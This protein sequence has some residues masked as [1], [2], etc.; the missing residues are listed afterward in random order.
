MKMLM[1]AASWLP[2]PLYLQGVLG[3]GEWFGWTSSVGSHLWSGNDFASPGRFAV[4]NHRFG[5]GIAVFFGHNKLLKDVGVV[6][7]TWR[8]EL[9]CMD[10]FW[11]SIFGRCRNSDAK[12][13]RCRNEDTE[14]MPLVF[15]APVAHDGMFTEV[16]CS[17]PYIYELICV[18]YLCVC[19]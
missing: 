13:S 6:H 9:W 16:E 10:F 12:L 7:K 14:I 2:T 19:V 18:L 4:L 17:C 15:V 1:E 8:C 11:C 5:L 3:L